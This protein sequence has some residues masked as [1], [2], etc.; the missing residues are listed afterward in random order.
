MNFAFKESVPN[1]KILDTHHIFQAPNNIVQKSS[2]VHFR[3]QCCGAGD[4]GAKIILKPEAGA[5]IIFIIYIICSQ[6]AGRKANFLYS[7]SKV[8]NIIENFSVALYGCSWSW[9]RSRNYGQRKVQPETEP[10]IN[11]SCSATLF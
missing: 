10:K 9:S 6:F 4:G 11:N 3:S 5:E 8:L 1:F 7:I 2:C